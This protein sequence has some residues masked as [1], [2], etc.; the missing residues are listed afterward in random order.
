MTPPWHRAPPRALATPAPARRRAGPPGGPPGRTRGSWESGTADR[1]APAWRCA[2][3]ACPCRRRTPT[4]PGEHRSGPSSCCRSSG[5][6]AW[7]QA[8][9]PTCSAWRKATSTSRSTSSTTSSTRRQTFARS[10]SA[11]RPRPGTC[12]RRGS[13]W[14]SSSRRS[15]WGTPASCWWTPASSQTARPGRAT[16]ATTSSPWACGAATWRGR[17]EESA[18]RRGGCST[19]TPRARMGACWRCPRRDSRRLARPRARMAT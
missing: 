1:R 15:P 7:T 2:S 9:Q 14:S 11:R 12:G 13:I 16:V 8:S 3:P 10:S 18:N 4:R 6:R 5:T 17:G 19:W